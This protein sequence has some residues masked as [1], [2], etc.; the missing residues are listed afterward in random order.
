MADQGQWF[1]TLARGMATT[2][3]RRQALR[4]AGGALG[5][6]ILALFGFQ[7]QEASAANDPNP[8]NSTCARWCTAQ[9]APG[10]A[11]G[12]CVSAAAKGTGPCY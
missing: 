1:D 5:A 10:A 7:A 11:R 4:A 9:F 6:L 3:S 2:T 12:Q 8:G